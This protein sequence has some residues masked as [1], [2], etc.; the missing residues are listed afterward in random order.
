M[1]LDDRA[2]LRTDLSELRARL[3]PAQQQLASAEL[4][5]NIQRYLGDTCPATIGAYLAVRGEINLD[6]VL[7]WLE[8]RCQV[9]LPVITDAAADIPMRFAPWSGKTPLRKGRYNISVPDVPESSYIDATALDLVLVPLV[10]FDNA[11]NRLGMGGGYYDRTFRHWHGNTDSQH[12]LIGVAHEIQRVDSVPV[13]A[14]DI[15]MTRI[16]TDETIH[17]PG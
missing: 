4:L 9:Y 15:P 7:R 17:I 14:W 12:R 8:E 13:E 11:G 2:T 3:T 1:T 6:P 5:L 16:I 10:G